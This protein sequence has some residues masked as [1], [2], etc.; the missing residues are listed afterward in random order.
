MATLKLQTDKAVVNQLTLLDS[1]EDTVSYFGAAANNIDQTLKYINIGNGPNQTTVTNM[2]AALGFGKA[3][4]TPGVTNLLMRGGHSP[5]EYTA[6]VSAAPGQGIPWVPPSQPIFDVFQGTSRLAVPI[7]IA[8]GG[9]TSIG[10]NG[11]TLSDGTPATWDTLVTTSQGDTVF[12][13][14]YHF[15]STG[16][17]NQLEAFVD[18]QAQFV[19]QDNVAGTNTYS[20]SI[21]V[22][23]LAPGQHDVTFL[24]TPT[25]TGDSSVSLSDFQLT[26]DS[27]P[28]PTALGALTVGALTLLARRRR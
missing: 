7:T 16:G 21:D 9:S 18:G 6:L 23:A 26:A 10:P 15:N 1:P 24:L 12:T 28:E 8:T 17:G 19:M 4:A 13:F 22:A 3:S 5:D 20:G 27:V 11:V 14:Q 2:V 25:G